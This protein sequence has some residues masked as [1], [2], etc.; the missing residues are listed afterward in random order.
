MPRRQML[1]TIRF[2]ATDTFVFSLAAEPDE[3]AIPGAFA[4]VTLTERDLVGKTRQEFANGFLSLHSF[5]RSTFACAAPID[6]TTVTALKAALAEHFVEAYGA[7]GPV[8]AAQAASDEIEYACSLASD[9]PINTVFAVHRSF[10]DDGE[11]REQFHVIEKTAPSWPIRIAESK[12]S[13]A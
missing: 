5:G 3:W 11:I 8:E 12:D 6:E 10:D 13:D 9:V 7:P 1:R 2:D 4:F